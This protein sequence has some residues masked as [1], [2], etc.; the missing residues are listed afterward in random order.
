LTPLSE[1]Q[2]T[3]EAENDAAMRMAHRT[4]FRSGYRHRE[5]YTPI[6][7]W[8]GFEQYAQ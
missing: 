5:I 1:M 7:I 3:A 6:G 2:G 8:Q 4:L